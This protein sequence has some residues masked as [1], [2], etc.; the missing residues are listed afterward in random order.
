[1]DQLLAS[2][3][4]LVRTP[5]PDA[6]AGALRSAGIAYIAGPDR[7][8]TVDV[9]DGRVSSQMVA[10]AA[11]DHGVLLTELRPTDS[12]GLEQLFFSLTATN[13]THAQEAAA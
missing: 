4:L 13:P 7:T 6:L 12:G 9:A 8:L 11:L 2:S 3:S 1:M 5:D 10:Q